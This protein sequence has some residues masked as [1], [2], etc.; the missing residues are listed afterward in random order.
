MWM[1]IKKQKVYGELIKN[2]KYAFKTLKNVR[3]RKTKT[4]YLN[5]IMCDRKPIRILIREMRNSTLSRSYSFAPGKWCC[6]SSVQSLRRMI[7]V[8]FIRRRPVGHS[9]F[10]R[11]ITITVDRVAFAGRTAAIPFVY[12]RPGVF[13]FVRP[14]SFLVPRRSANS[15]TSN[16]QVPRPF[17]LSVSPGFRPR[18]TPSCYV[19]EFIA[20]HRALNSACSL[21]FKPFQT[22]IVDLL[23]HMND[24][25]RTNA[26]PEIWVESLYTYYFRKR[27]TISSNRLFA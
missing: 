26:K 12:R 15:S 10:R 4:T 21:R 20:V 27:R 8:V 25:V 7:K 17:G 19:K 18:P 14:N 2:V 3:N 6:A 11:R 13:G 23:V 5:S 24:S 9:Q 22:D 1:I 16:Q